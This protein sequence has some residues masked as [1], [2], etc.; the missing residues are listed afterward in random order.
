MYLKVRDSLQLWVLGGM[1]I[2]LSHHHALL[3]EVLVDSNAVL[4]GHQH[5]EVLTSEINKMRARCLE[6]C[7]SN[8]SH[9][10]GT[11]GIQITIKPVLLEL[12]RV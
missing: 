9:I 8:I 12:D 6:Q 10:V 7:L 11:C 2:L 3:E 5:P 4:L 1:E